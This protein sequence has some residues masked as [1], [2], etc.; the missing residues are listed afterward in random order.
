M[1]LKRTIK[2]NQMARL[3]VLAATLGVI[4]ALDCVSCCGQRMMGGGGGGA[5][6]ARR[7]RRVAASRSPK[8]VAASGPASASASA[9][10]S[11]QASN[12]QQQQQPAPTIINNIHIAKK[13]GMLSMAE[14][15]DDILAEILRRRQAQ[16][17]HQSGPGAFA[18]ASGASAAAA[19][20]GAPHLAGRYDDLVDL[21]YDELDQQ[22]HLQQHL[23]QHPSHL[24]QPQQHLPS[25]GHL[26][27]QQ[28]PQQ[29]RR[30]GLRSRGPLAHP[31]A[32]MA[33]PIIRQLAA[34]L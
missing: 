21:E 33:A 2:T 25:P 3:T 7:A 20:S 12:Q 17:N 30:H 18:S 26:Q 14:L 10:A 4:L 27:Q 31:V 6:R 8:Q 32:R 22:Q 9:S 16:A 19:S 28:R 34:R 24:N 15:D 13:P 23:Q 5:M 1:R 11:A 29:H